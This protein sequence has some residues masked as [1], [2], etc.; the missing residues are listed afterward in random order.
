MSAGNVTPFPSKGQPAKPKKHKA[1]RIGLK[2]AVGGENG[3][4]TLDI[5]IGLRG[6]CNALDS[7]GGSTRDLDQYTDLSAAAAV[8]FGM[9]DE[10]MLSGEWPP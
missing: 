8:L 9:L 6:V 10:R 4:T 7:A 5:W 1:E 2:F 3:S